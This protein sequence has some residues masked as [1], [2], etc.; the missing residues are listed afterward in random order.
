MRTRPKILAIAFL[1]ILAL[2]ISVAPWGYVNAQI[3]RSHSTTERSSTSGAVGARSTL[4]SSTPYILAGG[5]NGEWFTPT[6]TP[7]LYKVTLSGLGGVSKSLVTESNSGAV[8]SGGWNGSDWLATGWGSGDSNGLNPYFDIYDNQ[9]QSE[10]YFSNYTQDSAAEQEWSGGDVFSATWNGSTWLL[11]GMG[12]GVL[13][14]GDGAVNHYS[15]AFLTSNGTFIDLSQSIPQNIDGILYAS[16]WNGFNWLVGGG[17]YGFNT[18][19]L[20]QVT[21]NGAIVDLTSVIKEWVPDF[22]TVQSIEWNGTDW[23]IGGVGF[24]ALYNPTTGAVYDLTDAL[25]SVLNTV[26]SLDNS[27]TNAVNSI[28]WTK[29]N[30]MLAGG[31]PVGFEGT[32]NQTAWVA[33]FDPQSG[34]FSDLTSQVIPFS[35]LHGSMSSILSMAC[36]DVGC[37]LG[38]FSGSNPVL[39][40]Y[41][42][43]GTM[44]LSYTLTS[45][46]MTYVQWVGV[47]DGV[48]TTASPSI[49]APQPGPRILPLGLLY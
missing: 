2:S 34:Q 31:A 9:V 8:W 27:M 15:M 41:K 5:Q 39:M 33:S 37:A 16:S 36:D 47:S 35:I 42:G 43:S 29:G 46:N 32:E 23:M 7:A 18:G 20:Y 26:D 12:S 48:S 21:P 25:D 3:S 30:W 22:S 13:T 14:P 28:V 38:G 11:T 4:S 17:W 10:L 1:M 24:L 44:D 45:G 49:H 6:Q 19:V 40:W